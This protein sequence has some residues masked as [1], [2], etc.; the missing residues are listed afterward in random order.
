MSNWHVET[1]IH[2]SIQDVRCEWF[3]QLAQPDY[4]LRYSTFYSYFF[5]LFC[6]VLIMFLSVKFLKVIYQVFEDIISQVFM[7]G[8]ELEI[9]KIRKSCIISKNHQKYNFL[10]KFSKLYFDSIMDSWVALKRLNTFLWYMGN[11]DFFGKGCSALCLEAKKHVNMLAKTR[12]LHVGFW[13]PASRRCTRP[14]NSKTPVS[15]TIVSKYFRPK[16]PLWSQYKVR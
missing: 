10:Q 12:K 5:Q 15:V 3:S 8:L 16:N 11:F 1:F 2:P 4:N 6:E 14:G 13:P 7:I 9:L